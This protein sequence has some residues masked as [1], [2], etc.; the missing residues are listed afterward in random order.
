MKIY[1]L[2]LVLI[3]VLRLTCLKTNSL[4]FLQNVKVLCWNS[5]KPTTDFTTQL[6]L[7]KH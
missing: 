4:R 7:D 3:S 2:K 6:T 1:L 5:L